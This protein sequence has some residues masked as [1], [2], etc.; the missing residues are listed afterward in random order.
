MKYRYTDVKAFF[1][2]AGYVMQSPRAGHNYLNSSVI[3]NVG[4]VVYACESEV[5]FCGQVKKGETLL[6]EKLP[7]VRK[8]YP[9]ARTESGAP[10]G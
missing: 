4:F 7:D 2:Q 3:N 8:R 10:G 9:A 1:E 5:S 6:D